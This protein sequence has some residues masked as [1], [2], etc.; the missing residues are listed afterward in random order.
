MPPEGLL[1]IL[2][3]LPASG[4]TTLAKLLAHR[5]DDVEIVSSDMLRSQ[6]SSGRIW[7]EMAGMVRQGLSAGKT[8]VVDAT[9]YN[10][11]HRDRYA[12]IAR[13]MGVPYLIACLEAEMATLL[14]RNSQ[15]T[16]RI[17]ESAI[18][19]LSSLFETP[20]DHAI[21]I[22]T[23]ELQPAEAFKAIM[24]RKTEIDRSRSS[25]GSETT[26]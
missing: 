6:L 11:A 8:V 12:R 14:Q 1:I 16:E 20:L 19:H 17:P 9:N 15:R 22:D 2:C 7:E 13:E 10:D 21:R 5:M 24:R 18:R 25:P 26:I 4:K 3:G 23:E